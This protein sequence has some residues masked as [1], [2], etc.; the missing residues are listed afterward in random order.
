MHLAD[1]WPAGWTLQER[2]NYAL[3]NS[4]GRLV[5][6]LDGHTLDREAAPGNQNIAR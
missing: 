2:A 5:F 6:D 1:V 3:E 4:M